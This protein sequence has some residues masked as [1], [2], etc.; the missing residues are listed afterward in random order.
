M[1]REGRVGR[2]SGEDIEC[3]GSLGEADGG[4]ALIDGTDRP[5]GRVEDGFGVRSDP[6]ACYP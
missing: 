5:E 2:L 3:V 6:G 1:Q 4:I